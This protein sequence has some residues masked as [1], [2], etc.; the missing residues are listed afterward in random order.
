MTLCGSS[1]QRLPVPSTNQS[2]PHTFLLKRPRSASTQSAPPAQANAKLLLVLHERI[3][4]THAAEP[5]DQVPRSSAL[6]PPIRDAN[7]KMLT[8]PVYFVFVFVFVY[9]RESTGYVR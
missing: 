4:I 8:F 5:S 1:L 2:T 7:A 3:S 9:F 6:L